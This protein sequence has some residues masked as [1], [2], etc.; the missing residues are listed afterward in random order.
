MN[1][2]KKN[3][4]SLALWLTLLPP[5]FLTSDNGLGTAEKNAQAT[6]SALQNSSLTQPLSSS[7]DGIPQFSDG[8]GGDCVAGGPGSKSCTYGSCS[9]ESG[10]CSGDQYACC[11]PDI[12][13]CS[14]SSL[15]D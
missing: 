9:V 7:L 13:K 10:T 3:V 2:V 15:M 5:F 12:C 8:D 14:G 11:G 4:G 1:L 6:G